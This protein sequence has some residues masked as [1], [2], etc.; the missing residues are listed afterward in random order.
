MQYLKNTISKTGQRTRWTLVSESNRSYCSTSAV[1]NN[2]W[3]QLEGCAGNPAGICSG[4]CAGPLLLL[5]SIASSATSLSKENNPKDIRRAITTENSFF[6]SRNPT[7]SSVTFVRKMDLSQRPIDTFVLTFSAVGLIFLAGDW[8]LR[9]CVGNC[10]ESMRLMQAAWGEVGVIRL[11]LGRRLVNLLPVAQQT[12][13]CLLQLAKDARAS[14]SSKRNVRSGIRTRV[15]P[16]MPIVKAGISP[17]GYWQKVNPSPT[18]TK[19]YNTLP[20]FEQRDSW[21]SYGAVRAYSDV[22]L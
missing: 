9:Q 6:R 20:P 3:E 4:N 8:R 7:I 16:S 19:P 15:L 10:A 21:S 13:A 14:N 11:S 17:L 18:Q 22:L 2:S 12:N 1:C 5:I